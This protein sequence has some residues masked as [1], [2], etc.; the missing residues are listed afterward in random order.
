MIGSRSPEKARMCAE[1]YKCDAGTYEDVLARK[2]ID[3]VYISL[4]NTLHEEWAIKAAQAGKH[5]WCEKPSALTCTS[6]ERM[7]EACTQNKVRLME[8]FMFLSH[9]Q[10]K[11]VR[12]LIIGGALGEILKFEGCFAFPFPEKDSVLLNANLGGGSLNDSAV[13]PIC[14]SRMIFDDEPV[15]VVCNMV[16]DTKAGVDTKIDILLMYPGGRSAFISSVFGSYFQSTYSVLGN[17]GKITMERAYAVPKD[18]QVKIF[19]DTDDTVTEITIDPADHFALMI[20][21]FCEEIKKGEKSNRHYEDELLAEARVLDAARK[22]FE[23]G[24]VVLLQEV[25][26]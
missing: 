12:E 22:S 2:D 18:R 21:E 10:H 3:A 7:L 14:A 23:E 9:P 24:R 25:S 8:G 6:A 5:I 17:K 16:V 13:Y 20:D 19:F 4:P 15:S 11:K 1:E 26:S